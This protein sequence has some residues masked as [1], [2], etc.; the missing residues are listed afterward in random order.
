MKVKIVAVITLLSISA[1]LF[2]ACA[3]TPAPSPTPPPAPTTPPT[4]SPVPSPTPT[5]THSGTI[6][7]YVT[8]APPREQVTSIMVTVSEV[9]VHMAEAEQEQEQEQSASDN[10]T[11]EQELEQ[12]QEQDGEGKWITIGLSDNATTFDLL[13]IKGI[14]Q[15][16][17]A[18]EVATGKYTQVRLVV[19]TIQVSLGEGELQDATVPSNELKIVRPF[20]VIAGETTALILDFEADKMVTV[21]GAGKIIVKPVVK[22]SIKHK[23]SAGKPK[24]AEEKAEISLEDTL[25]KLESYGEKE[26]LQTVIQDTEITIEFKSAESKIAGSGGCNSYFGGYEI[27]KNE[28]TIIPPIGS[29]MMACPEPIMDQEQEYLAIL[30]LTESYEMDG[31]ELRINCG[32]QVLI[33]KPE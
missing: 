21:T 3:P 14:E 4:P 31:N 27:I 29:T 23:D 12:E 11:P 18:S 17:G 13:E 32:S 7:V 16:L 20:D 22:L 19:D 8:D 30:Q 6:Q 15:Y 1:L 2:G 24:E 28:L 10:E 25:W 9:Q 5:P 33:F 26:N